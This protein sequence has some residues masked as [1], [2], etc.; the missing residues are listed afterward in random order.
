MS[1]ADLLAASPDYLKSYSLTCEPFANSLDGRFFYGGSALMQRLDLLTHLTQFG[2]S[3]ILVSGPHGSGKTTLLGRFAGQ[4]SKQWRL[5]LINAHEFEQFHQRLGDALGIGDIDNEQQMLERWASQ[6]E[7]SQLLVIVIDNAEQLQAA[8]FRKLCS[9]L[10]QPLADRVR[11]ILFGTPEAL[12]ALKQ[13]FD[14]NELPC[15]AQLLEVPR[16]TEEET[17]SYLMYR[18]AV[19]G[20]SG[21]SP[22]TATEVRAMCKAADGRPADINRLAHEA[23]LEHQIRTRSRRL[24]PRKQLRKGTGLIWGLSSLL[25]VGIAA[26]LG[27]QHLPSTPPPESTLADN[28]ALPGEEIP[29]NLPEPGERQLPVAATGEPGGPAPQ[30]TPATEILA[31]TETQPTA[32]KVTV[33]PETP[34]PPPS[35]AEEAKV[36]PLPVPPEAPLPVTPHLPSVTPQPPPIAEAAPEIPRPAA[37][38]LKPAATPKP[39]AET[40]ATAEAGPGPAATLPHDEAWL[41]EQPEQNYSLQLLGSRQAGSITDYIKQHH[42]DM[43]KS[44]VYRGIYRGSE[45]YVLLYGI[46]PSRQAALEARA[47]LPA[48]VRKDKPWPRTL[49]SVHT[50]IREAQ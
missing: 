15:T 40:A 25:V 13:S 17:A 20:Y 24:Q 35:P 19:A 36:E 46:Y 18:L 33:S 14:Q 23:L 45:W 27:W 43:E 12:Q 48:K 21:E 44:A 49:K 42:L 29:L 7:A 37:E 32:A 34:L 2:D 41:L 4:A 47:G 22:F 31:T 5:C 39:A 6:T 3:V 9:L 10:K 50:A 26:Y 1:N 8:D 28:K 30:E 11:L 16:L 38:T